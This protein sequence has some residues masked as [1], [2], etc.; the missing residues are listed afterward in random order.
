[1]S[2]NLSILVTDGGSSS[3]AVCAM[4]G[5]ERARVASVAQ[6]VR[7]IESSDRL[8]N[9]E[10]V[11]RSTSRTPRMSQLPRNDDGNE[12]QSPVPVGR[13]TDRASAS[14]GSAARCG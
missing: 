6:N 12:A 8:V 9:G 2:E 13:V 1:M 4:S 5:E 11:L 7:I 3:G 10:P 14:S